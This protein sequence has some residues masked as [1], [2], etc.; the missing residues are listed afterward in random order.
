MIF[1]FFV[2]VEKSIATTT[3]TSIFFRNEAGT[4]EK[5]WEPLTLIFEEGGD[6]RIKYGNPTA[7]ID[8]ETGVIWL[9]ANRDYLTEKGARAGGTLVLFQS[10]DNGLSWS[11][12][13]D[14]TTSIKQSDWGHYAFGPGIGIQIQNGDHQ[15]RLLFPG[16][17]RKSFNKR[18]PSWSHVIYSDDHG[19]TWKMGGQLGE[20][21]NECQVA[22]IMDGDRSGLLINARNHWGRAG[23][24][25]KSGNR[26]VARSFDGGLTWQGERM[27]PSLPEPPC[28][29]ALFRYTLSTDQGEVNRILFCNPAGPGRSKLTLRL[30]RDEG[31]TWPVSTI[32]DSGSSAYSCL[33]RLSDGRVGIVY[34]A[35]NYGRISFVRVSRE[36]V[37]Q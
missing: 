32:I 30:S 19:A 37:L 13:I 14:I 10:A 20:Y 29:A 8:S 24:P 36:W 31:R 6:A 21:T 11:K 16:N 25:D 2:R 18:K 5:T 27:D 23:V 35:S 17:Y 34:E 1:S 15:G 4:E 12:P 7:V 9:A 33:T 22:E 28:Q 26:I 3:A